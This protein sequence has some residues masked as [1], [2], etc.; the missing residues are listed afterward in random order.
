MGTDDTDLLRKAMTESAPN[1]AARQQRKR[2]AVHG[3]VLRRCQQHQAEEQRRDGNH[4][5]RLCVQGYKVHEE[6][7]SL[8]GITQGHEA[9]L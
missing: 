2:P 5:C 8:E 7:E 9:A 6:P 1:V 4:V 3:D